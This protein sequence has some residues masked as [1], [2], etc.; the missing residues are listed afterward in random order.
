[1]AY[2]AP[3][4]KLS[5]LTN[6]LSG[7]AKA[8]NDFAAVKLERDKMAQQQAQFDA[9]LNLGFERLDEQIR[10]ADMDDA[11]RREMQKLRNDLAK[12][13]G[14]E[15]RASAE[16]RTRMQTGPQY[17]RLKDAR[18][19]KDYQTEQQNSKSTAIYSFVDT[20]QPLPPEPDPT[21]LELFPQ[22]ANDMR[23]VSA[24]A[25]RNDAIAFQTN[26]LASSLSGFDAGSN[27]QATSEIRR[28]ANDI[29]MNKQAFKERVVQSVQ[30][31]ATAKAQRAGRNAAFAR[32]SGS[33]SSLLPDLSGKSAEG[34]FGGWKATDGIKSAAIY[35]YQAGPAD[36][37][38]VP[39]MV[40]TGVRDEDL[41]KKLKAEPVVS[42]VQQPDANAIATNIAMDIQKLDG[43][44]MAE[45]T[46]L[47]NKWITAMST[48]VD[49]IQSGSNQ[50]ISET[51][52]QALK[53]ASELDERM[54]YS[55]QATAFTRTRLDW[56]VFAST[57]GGPTNLQWQEGTTS[58]QQF[59]GPGQSISDI[60]LSASE[61]LKG[62]EISLNPDDEI[63]GV[64]ALIPDGVDPDGGMFGEAFNLTPE[65]E[66]LLRG[67]NS[68]VPQVNTEDMLAI[69]AEVNR[70]ESIHGPLSASQVGDVYKRYFGVK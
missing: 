16:K 45:A 61:E 60:F 8:M 23:F 54:G 18:E 55:G 27:Q 14:I 5:M 68:Q 26:Q 57:P 36:E 56:E 41:E 53:L 4:N 62:K 43:Q 19:W 13:E 52:R 12:S 50:S 42:Y 28:R 10:K 15:D 11:T 21:N 67:T 34:T 63:S 59:S 31:T 7:T 6:A 38:G 58:G 65:Q 69:K 20:L 32:A 37:R 44:S 9:N 70:L 25:M 22:G 24:V 30:E 2:V 29:V 17:Q 35:G 40:Y 3:R 33:Y 1:M 64:N 46:S 66:L 48:H 39:G 49:S 47:R 51:R